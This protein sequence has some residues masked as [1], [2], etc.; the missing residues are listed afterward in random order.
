MMRRGTMV[1]WGLL[2]GL[3][4]MAQEA[5]PQ[6][7]PIQD[8]SFMVEEAYNQEDG[9]IQHIFTYS[10]YQKSQDW[11]ATF[12]EEW[13]APSQ[14]HQLSFT[15]PYLR[16]ASS[17]DGRKAVG[18][19][20][21][22][23]RYQLL[24]DGGSVVAMSPR[25]SI[26][27]PT[28]DEKQ[29]RGAGA[30]GYQVNLPLS[31]ALGA[32]FVTHLNLGSTYTPGAR[33]AAGDRA[34]LT[35]WNFGQSFIWLARSNFNAMLEF[36]GTLGEQVAGPAMKERVNTLFVNPGFRWAINF[37]SGLQIVPGIAFPI[38]VGPSK[39]ERAVFFYV[40]FEHPLWRAK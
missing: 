32:H 36:A 9:V 5:A 1:I 37:K 34:D 14:K 23:Y 31:V 29:L 20:A 15:V 22:N 21:L 10:R 16:M 25:F 19:V 40:S 33:N 18:D 4:L 28:G 7:L 30:T 12:T 35:A 3:G 39:G 13:P 27:L 17:L 26:L 11:L 8:N 24:G 6:F 38:G 2:A